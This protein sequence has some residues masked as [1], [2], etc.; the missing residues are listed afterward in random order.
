M[1]QV[2]TAGCLGG[3]RPGPHQNTAITILKNKE[4]NTQGGGK[5]HAHRERW[6]KESDRLNKE[7]RGRYY[8]PGSQ[9]E[10]K[11]KG[12][13]KGGGA[14][15][16]VL[17][18]VG[19]EWGGPVPKELKKKVNVPL[20]PIKGGQKTREQRQKSEKRGRS[21][22][23]GS[24]SG[25][26]ALAGGGERPIGPITGNLDPQ[27]GEK[28]GEPEQPTIQPGSEV[29]SG[30]K[31]TKGRAKKRSGKTR[32]PSV[33]QGL[34]GDSNEQKGRQTTKNKKGTGRKK[35][36][37]FR[38]KRGGESVT[39]GGG[40]PVR[41]V[42][43]KTLGF[44]T[45]NQVKGVH[46]GQAPGNGGVCQQGRIA[47]ESYRR[48]SGERRRLITHNNEK[49]TEKG[50]KVK[51]GKKLEEGVPGKKPPTVGGFSRNP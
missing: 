16:Q 3:K 32:S 38:I 25:V 8:T 1:S 7:P 42:G 33:K 4:K 9:A 10:K 5:W 28:G 21:R 31:K 22:K 23:R 49:D 6:T 43:L 44:R 30:T 39:S 2:D 50:G 40:L 45:K 13:K 20:G 41:V 37:R 48:H 12:G 24:Y 14:G 27:P 34:G 17:N 51:N 36:E 26:R 15:S 29:F 47:A 35:G 11:K 19:R 18:G 46:E